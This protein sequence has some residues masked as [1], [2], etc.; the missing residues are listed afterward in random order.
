MWPGKCEKKRM[1]DKC[2]C[3]VTRADLAT[4][5]C[6]TSQER[7]IEGKVRVI[8]RKKGKIRRDMRMVSKK[9]KELNSL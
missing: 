1:I 9:K 5:E 3:C 6:F 8:K 4:P 2:R 7:V